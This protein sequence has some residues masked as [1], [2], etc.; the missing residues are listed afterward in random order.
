MNLSPQYFH[1]AISAPRMHVIFSMICLG[2]RLTI[3]KFNQ[4]TFP[5]SETVDAPIFRTIRPTIFQVQPRSDLFISQY[6]NPKAVMYW[7]GHGHFRIDE[8]C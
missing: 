6:P 7:T 1:L 5:Y 8:K 2:T 4:A 3:W